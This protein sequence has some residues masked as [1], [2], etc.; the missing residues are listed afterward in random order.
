MAINKPDFLAGY[1]LFYESAR[2]GGDFMAAIEN[3]RNLPL[4]RTSPGRRAGTQ[5]TSHRDLLA[6]LAHPPAACGGAG[7]IS[8]KKAPSSKLVVLF[9]CLFAVRGGFEQNQAMISY[10]PLAITI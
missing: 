3:N 8:N 4:A 6:A 9:C 7:Q 1:S 10:N 2:Y 5:S